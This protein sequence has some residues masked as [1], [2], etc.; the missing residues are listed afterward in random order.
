MRAVH[1]EHFEDPRLVELDDEFV[2]KSG[3]LL[4]GFVDIVIRRGEMLD[5]P[6]DAPPHG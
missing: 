4:D 3:D 2:A 6:S 5:P 1:S